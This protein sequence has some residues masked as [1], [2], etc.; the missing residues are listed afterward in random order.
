M[1]I[2]HKLTL[3]LAFQITQFAAMITTDELRTISENDQL[4]DLITELSPE[5]FARLDDANQQI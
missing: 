4:R 1:V 2:Y 5:F 3:T